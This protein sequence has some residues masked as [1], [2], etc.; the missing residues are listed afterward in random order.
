MYDERRPFQPH[1]PLPGPGQ[2]G[3]NQRLSPAHDERQ[4]MQIQV[5]NDGDGCAHVSLVNPA[6]GET[7]STTQVLA[8][9]QLTV[10]AVNAHEASDIE[11][12]QVEPAPESAPADSEPP[13]S[14]GEAPAEE[15]AAEG[16]GE[17]ASE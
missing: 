7:L 11:V 12:G 10:T 16:E 1:R 6:T 8:D 14:G 4:Q 9:Q 17:P 13:A 5:L 2:P 3:Y 15:P